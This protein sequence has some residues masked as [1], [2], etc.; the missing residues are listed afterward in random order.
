MGRMFRSRDEEQSLVQS[1]MVQCTKRFVLPTEIEAGLWYVHR[2]LPQQCGDRVRVDH[3]NHSGTYSVFLPDYGS[4]KTVSLSSLFMVNPRLTVIAPLAMRL[5]L[6]GVQPQRD[7]TE[8][9]VQRFA[10]LVQTGTPLT[11]VLVDTTICE[12]VFVDRLHV[13]RLLSPT[14]GDVAKCLVREGHAKPLGSLGPVPL[15]ARPYHP[16]RE[17]QSGPPCSPSTNTE[18]P[19]VAASNLGF[20]RG[21]HIS[22]PCTL[23]DGTESRVSIGPAHSS[24][25]AVIYPALAPKVGSCVLGRVSAVFGPSCFYLV[26]PFGQRS[27]KRLSTTAST[28]REPLEALTRDLQDVCNERSFGTTAGA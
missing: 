14:H 1:L 18:D 27:T 26:F 9:A 5:Q 2:E 7:W 20:R 12:E 4:R 21:H 17:E 10:E 6:S 24:K 16:V 13:V 23:D 25:P 3:F 8:A 19:G 11:A 28:E 22:T 15:P